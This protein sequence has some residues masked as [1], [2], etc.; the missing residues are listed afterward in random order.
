MAMKW[1]Q[2]RKIEVA[3]YIIVLSLAII[4]GAIGIIFLSGTF[5][6]FFINLSADFL[7]VAILFFL[8]NRFFGLDQESTI[9]QQ[10][11]M[12]RNLIEN[13]FGVLNDVKESKDKFNFEK[14]LQSAEQVDVIGYNLTSFLDEFRGKIIEQVQKGTKVRVIVVDPNSLAR[15]MMYKHSTLHLYDKDIIQTFGFVNYINDGLS[16]KGQKKKFEF[17]VIDWIPSCS[18]IIVDANKSTGIMN[19]KVNTPSYRTPK[20]ESRL[21][22]I[23]TQTEQPKWFEFFA[24]QFNE[25]WE[26]SY[27]WDGSYPHFEEQSEQNITS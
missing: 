18:L 2:Q 26:Y 9:Q 13:K 7:G 4:L 1:S 27:P 23:F 8:V 24:K 15:E 22:L 14:L 25:L 21:H 3:V 17:R 20:Y 19:V 12:V 11:D 10:F 16:R 5:R 6:D